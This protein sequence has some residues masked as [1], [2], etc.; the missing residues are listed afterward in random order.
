MNQGSDDGQTR[1]TTQLREGQ[2]I[3]HFL[4]E[5]RLGKGGMGSVYL[6]SDVNLDRKVAL[7]SL[8]AD[9]AADAEFQTRFGREAKALAKLNHPNIVGIYEFFQFEDRSFIAMEYVEG[10]TLRDA[11]KKS[12]EEKCH[13]AAELAMGLK[14]AHDEGIIHRDV[15]PENIMLNV[16]GRV[17]ILDF[18][19]AQAIHLGSITRAGLIVG[20]PDYMSPEQ[21]KGLTVDKRSDIFSFGIVLYE[22]MIGKRPFEGEFAADIAHK[23]VTEPPSKLDSA[24]SNVPQELLRI[25]GRCLEKQPEDR[26]QDAGQ[27]RD[28]LNYFLRAGK[29]GIRSAGIESM[30]GFFKRLLLLSPQ[31][32][33]NDF[34]TLPRLPN[35]S[36][37]LAGLVLVTAAIVSLLVRP[38]KETRFIRAFTASPS[39]AEKNALEILNQH[40]ANLFG[41]RSYTVRE[42]DT[43][44][45]RM[46]RHLRLP[47]AAIDSLERWRPVLRYHT[48]FVSYDQKERYD[49][50]SY[51]DGRFYSFRHD[52]PPA[53]DYRNFATDTLIQITRRY[54]NLLTGVEQA[55]LTRLSPSTTVTAGQARAELVWESPVTLPAK[56]V[57]EIRASFFGGHL[58]SLESTILTPESLSRSP[59]AISD[60]AGDFA[61]FLLFLIVLLLVAIVIANSLWNFVAPKILLLSFAIFALL[62]LTIDETY[63]NY[64][65]EGASVLFSNALI[66]L[67]LCVF[68]FLIY[69]FLPPMIRILAQLRPNSVAGILS[70]DA[71]N[72]SANLFAI[73]SSIGFVLGATACVTKSLFTSFIIGLFGVG[74]DP[75]LPISEE[76]PLGVIMGLILFPIVA[77]VGILVLVTG[78]TVLEKHWRWGRPAWALFAVVISCSMEPSYFSSDGL[79]NALQVFWLFSWAVLLWV[80]LRHG[81]VTGMMSWFAYRL[82]DVG[83]NHAVMTLTVDRVLGLSVLLVWLIIASYSTYYVVRRVKKPSF[84][85]SS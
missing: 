2:K 42:R 77:L 44:L 11:M 41:F 32:E 39:Q 76:S 6:A 49:L 7:K 71:K 15:K 65:D 24:K 62:L 28:D 81:I 61:G 1:L 20:T 47:S 69:T 14:A 17:K 43:L 80:S 73:S 52:F 38:P 9:L 59:A 58:I 74:L 68:L 21:V 50:Y 31:E 36:L 19:I 60:P 54:A 22:S 85:V 37:L 64:V 56:A 3:G 84:A 46:C 70:R 30:P 72:T 40:G 67:S 10:G 26:Y 78:G 63:Q 29:S 34:P 51:P 25:I 82:V 12:I 27:I 35:R 48:A 55:N 57:G 13:I 45:F 16:N 18:G 23:I 5:R 66:L 33:H 79:I 4:I 53:T 75:K 83:Y 8:S